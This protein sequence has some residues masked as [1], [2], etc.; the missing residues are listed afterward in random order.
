MQASRLT[1]QDG[2]RGGRLLGHSDINTTRI[3][4]LPTAAEKAE[5]LDLLVVGRV[6]GTHHRQ[7]EHLAAL[8]A[9]DQEGAVGVHEPEDGEQLPRLAL[10][11]HHMD[12]EHGGHPVTLNALT[13]AR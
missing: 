1:S 6:S 9:G 10:D 13:A 2:S 8:V 7:L 3:Y 11:H 5:A 12:R 4:T